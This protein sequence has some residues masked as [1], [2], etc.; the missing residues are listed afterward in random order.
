M[1]NPSIKIDLKN[2]SDEMSNWK[3][4]VD[5]FRSEKP[6]IKNSSS[7][8][9]NILTSAGFSDQSYN[10][11]DSNI[12]NAT[13]IIQ[14]FYSSVSN[15]L[16]NMNSDDITIEKNVPNAEVIYTIDTTNNVIDSA[17]INQF[18]TSN[19]SELEEERE[20]LNNGVVTS[21]ATYNDSYDDVT[22][23]QLVDI[24]KDDTSEVTFDDSSNVKYVTLTELLKNGDTASSNYDSSSS[25]VQAV[26]KNIN[27]SND[28]NKSYYDYSSKIKEK[29][30]LYDMI[31]NKTSSVNK[32]NDDN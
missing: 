16:D 3:S 32:N 13:F 7:N 4:K 22:S 20:E 21:Q 27:N 9:F 8:G 11:F 14:N 15:Y 10:T 5:V 30:T 26:L 29:E 6:S 2:V 25:V 24:T 18:T 1:K 17:S 12:D 19:M 31:H 28:T 23:E